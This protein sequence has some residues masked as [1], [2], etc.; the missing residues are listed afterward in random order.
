MKKG[1]DDVSGAFTYLQPSGG[2]MTG[3]MSA[4]MG[5]GGM[6]DAVSTGTMNS[7][8]RGLD[9]PMAPN[10]IM[11]SGT[12]TVRLMKNMKKSSRCVKP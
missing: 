10:K 3:A 7:L 11:Q 6:S 5:G 2:A 1:T 12:M 9:P 4:G 8:G